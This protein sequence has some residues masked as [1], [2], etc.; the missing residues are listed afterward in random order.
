[1]LAPIHTAKQGHGSFLCLAVRQGKVVPAAPSPSPGPPSH[2]PPAP[3]AHA[4]WSA[5]GKGDRHLHGSKKHTL[6]PSAPSCPNSPPAQGDES[7]GEG[8]CL[9]KTHWCHDY[10]GF[11]MYLYQLRL[12]LDWQTSGR[13]PHMKAPPLRNGLSHHSAHHLTFT[14]RSLCASV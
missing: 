6:T 7:W 13:E 10:I 4:C 1:M 2:Q 11:K 5:A 3:P 9:A 12:H 8:T 14:L